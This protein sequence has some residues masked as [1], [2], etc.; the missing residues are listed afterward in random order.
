MDFHADIAVSFKH[1]V[2][3]TRDVFEPANPTLA[4]V[5]EPA[6]AGPARVLAFVD[7][8]VAAAVPDLPDRLRAYAAAHADR[9]TLVDRVQPVLGGELCKNDR[10]A[11]YRVLESIASSRI[12]RQSYVLVIGGGAVL[13]CVGFAA[14]IAHRGV[15][16]V[17]LPTTTLAQADSGVGVKNG[18]NGFGQKNFLGTFATPW[19]VVND[20]RFLETLSDRDWRCGFIEAVKVGLIKDAS[21]FEAVE[22]A[23]PAIVQRELAVAVPIIRRS[24]ELH[25]RHIADGGDPFETTSARPL[26]FGHWAAHRLETLSGFTVRHGEAVAIGIALDCVYA[27]NIGLMSPADAERVRLCLQRLGFTLWD[28]RLLDAD[29]ILRGLDDFREHL[30]GP[31]TVT[32][33]HGIGE[34]VDVQQID[35]EAMRQALAALRPVADAAPTR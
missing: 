23:A 2:R 13:D 22:R 8:H 16:L 17:R 27:K 18:I 29:A 32:L 26:D 30:G 19:A 20:E 33:L 25:L 14:A 34:A 5:L 35:R 4:D 10:D 31:L 7:T 28:D 1:R 12:D 9:L 3:F 6:T 15:R 11:T 24:A 21:L